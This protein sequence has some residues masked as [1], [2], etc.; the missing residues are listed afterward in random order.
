MIEPLVASGH[1]EADLDFLPVAVGSLEE[2]THDSKAGMVAVI[3]SID[4]GAPG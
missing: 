3:G 1:A 2:V 4:M